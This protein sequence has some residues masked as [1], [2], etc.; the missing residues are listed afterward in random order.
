MGVKKYKYYF[1]KPKSEIVKDVISWLAIAGTVYI[2]ASSPYFV[3][4]LMRN[5]KKLRRYPKK[6]ITNTFYNLKRQNLIKIEKKNQQI[7]IRL[8]EKGKRKASWFQIDSLRINQPKKW[9][10]NWR[11]V[12]FDIAQIKKI[13]REA[14]RGKLKELGFHQLQK[15]VWVHAF[16]CQAEIDLLKDFFGLSSK[17]LRLIIS[18]DIGNNKEL[19]RFFKLEE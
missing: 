16:D 18:R 15:S 7:Y 9:D 6:K 2:A 13:Y 1:K 4:N 17:E 5:F 11:I 14:F 12:L 8:T 19:K 10:R 3:I